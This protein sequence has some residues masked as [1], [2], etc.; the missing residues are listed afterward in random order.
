MKPPVPQPLPDITTYHKLGEV[1]ALDNDKHFEE[2]IE[3]TNP[4]YKS[5]QKISGRV[6]SQ[7]YANSVTGLHVKTFDKELNL[8][9]F[10]IERDTILD[11]L[12]NALDTQ[13]TNHFDFIPK[14]IG[15]FSTFELQD[16]I[17]ISSRNDVFQ[18]TANEILA[19][20][21]CDLYYSNYLNKY[22][23]QSER[24]MSIINMTNAKELLG[25]KISE[26]KEFNFKTK[27]P[28]V[29]FTKGSVGLKITNVNKTL[30]TPIQP[31]DPIQNLND[32]GEQI[33]PI[34]K[35]KDKMVQ[36]YEDDIK[37]EIVSAWEKVSF[38]QSIPNINFEVTQ[39]Y[40]D[41]RHG[42]VAII[43]HLL[44]VANA[45]LLKGRKIEEI[46]DM[47]GNCRTAL[48]FL[49]TRIHINR[50]VFT[51]YD[52]VRSIDVRKFSKDN[53]YTT[54]T[55]TDRCIHLP[56][57]IK[58]VIFS[59]D[60]LYHQLEQTLN[61]VC[62]GYTVLAN[63]H[64]FD[65]DCL[66]API[67]ASVNNNTYKAGYWHRHGENIVYN[68]FVEEGGEAYHHP[69][70]LH[71]LY[72]FDHIIINNDI[73]I[74]VVN[75]VILYHEHVVSVLIR[76]QG[77]MTN[78]EI[79]STMV[80]TLKVKTSQKGKKIDIKP[81]LQSGTKEAMFYGD[82]ESHKIVKL[83]AEGYTFQS[84]SYYAKSEDFDQMNQLDKTFDIKPISNDVRNK[85]IKADELPALLASDPNLHAHYC[86]HCSNY[87]IHAHQI[88]RDKKT[89]KGAVD[90]GQLLGLH[91]QRELNCP[92]ITCKQY[93]HLSCIDKCSKLHSAF[94][95]RSIKDVL[96]N[97]K[98]TYFFSDDE[99]SKMKQWFVTYREQLREG[100]KDR[101][102]ENKHDKIDSVIPP[103][104]VISAFP[105]NTLYKD[106]DDETQS[107]AG[108]HHSLKVSSANTH[109]NKIVKEILNDEAYHHLDVINIVDVHNAA[110]SGDYR[111]IQAANVLGC[112]NKYFKQLQDLAHE[113]LIDT[114]IEY[115]NALVQTTVLSKSIA[116]II[117]KWSNN[118]IGKSNA[119][120]R[121]ITHGIVLT[122][123]TSSKTMLLTAEQIN[124]VVQYILVNTA[125]YFC[126]TA[127]KDDN[128]AAQTIVSFLNGDLIN[129][130]NG[131]WRNLEKHG[132]TAAFKAALETEVNVDINGEHE[133]RTTVCNLFYKIC[134]STYNILNV[135]PWLTEQFINTVAAFRGNK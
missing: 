47:C 90:P 113:S 112:D 2:L 116:T 115:H 107:E 34:I 85:L 70:V 59:N 1:K 46:Y 134:K 58:S 77:E 64:V 132:P 106:M 49:G 13:V 119:N 97:H 123:V 124:T 102:P 73:C 67:L 108:D 100:M 8:Q 15:I 62:D 7:L 9:S 130:T 61:Y 111:K 122:F 42:A 75:R 74:S 22:L 129:K 21:T 125:K 103:A 39:N 76:K 135:F 65:K 24:Y 118:N 32:T 83:M 82:E 104:K 88:S 84:R 110:N 55:C 17:Y 36:Q 80:N 72:N 133:T 81:F 45:L 92:Y 30:Q 23:D 69:D 126:V 28:M 71:Q 95:Q 128:V 14:V 87:Y 94:A 38:E 11:N 54:C 5:K 19:T 3:T 63:L 89:Q 109:F 25:T 121:E 35:I 50:P 120:P 41:N 6:Y 44:H 127:T 68:V 79:M 26:V 114:N 99:A 91:K 10:D 52:I 57:S 78:D 20:I 40:Y 56:K 43:R 37:P 98:P 86:D 27:I 16:L 33:Q 93:N 66:G 51:P 48:Y 12:Y 18:F 117:R 131:F 105:N 101:Y 53:G 60:S 31:R 4:E 96:Q 29:K